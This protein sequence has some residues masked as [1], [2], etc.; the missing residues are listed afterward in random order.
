MGEQEIPSWESLNDSWIVIDESEDSNCELYLT[1]WCFDHRPTSL[2]SFDKAEDWS[3]KTDYA[4]RRANEVNMNEHP[5][6]VILDLGCT[7]AMGSRKAVN[8]FVPAAGAAGLVVEFL[9]SNARFSFAN[10][11]TAQCREMMRVW[12]PTEPWSSTCFDIVEEGSV[13]M[14]FSL[15]QMRN[16]QFDLYIRRDGAWVD[17]PILGT[18]RLP[19]STSK[20]L[21][22]DLCSIKHDSPVSFLKEQQLAIVKRE[23][24]AFAT[25]EECCVAKGRPKTRPPGQFP[26]GVKLYSVEGKAPRPCYGCPPYNRKERHICGKEL[27]LFGARAPSTTITPG[28]S[29]TEPAK[30]IGVLPKVAG[31]PDVHGTARDLG[32]PTKPSVSPEKNVD[33]IIHEKEKNFDISETEGPAEPGT[34]ETTSESVPVSAARSPAVTVK[35]EDAEDKD[36]IKPLDPSMSSVTPQLARL[37]KRLNSK[38]E[39]YKLHLKHYHMSLENFKRRTSALALP[40]EVYDK[41]KQI[42]SNCEVCSNSLPPPQRARVSG[43]HA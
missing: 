2:A 29:S 17:S 34:T 12:F 39:L 20:H 19:V 22:L 37:H 4:N 31:D 38:V 23:F 10:S 13:P 35:K 33:V 32:V 36:K 15:V 30:S 9:P 41:Y 7:R 43:L 11:Q 8:K 14:L 6:L 24:P 28:S 42:V 21:C 27:K 26:T 18:Q 25:A 5:T 16:L 3:L 1:E 40:Q